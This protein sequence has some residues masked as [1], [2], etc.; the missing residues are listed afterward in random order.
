MP[1]LLKLLTPV[2]IVLINIKSLVPYIMIAIIYG[3]AFFFLALQIITNKKSTKE[4][5]EFKGYR[6]LGTHM[7]LYLLTFGLWQLVW[8]YR[9]T[10]YVNTIC[11]QDKMLPTGNIVM[12]IFIPFYSLSWT[13]KIAKRVDGFAG[14]SNIKTKISILATFLSFFSDAAASLVIQSKINESVYKSYRIK[15]ASFEKTKVCK[16]YLQFKDNYINI[17]NHLV[18]MFV[19][20]GVWKLIWV[21]RT[22]RMLNLVKGESYRSPIKK[23]LLC[24]FIPLYSIYW[25]YKT[26]IRLDN[27]YSQYNMD[28]DVSK[29][30]LVCGCLLININV[31]SIVIQNKINELALMAKDNGGNEIEYSKDI[32]ANYTLEENVE[33]YHHNLGLYVLGSLIFSYVFNPIWVYRTTKVLNSV[34]GSEKRNPIIQVILCVFL[35]LLYYIFWLWRSARTVDKLAKQYNV[36]SWIAVPSVVCAILFSLIPAPYIIQVKMNEIANY[37]KRSSVSYDD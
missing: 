12:C 7:L 22:T 20:F 8:M 17:F 1:V 16:S 18:L 10:K 13:Y 26:A 33:K 5:E 21:Y 4:D 35:P 37:A 9:T 15:S 6:Y 36:D 24:L 25:N 32:I 19:T 3:I 11:P 29:A 28:C 23:M 14:Q 2:L 34:N 27:L 31:S 30:C